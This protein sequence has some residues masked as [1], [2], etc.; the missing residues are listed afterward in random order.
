MGQRSRRRSEPEPGGLPAGYERSRAR[1][2]EIRAGLEPLEEGE[3]PL[4]V[5]IA[6]IVA[7]V[8]ALANIGLAIGGHTIAGGDDA[9]AL[10]STILSTVILLVA[11][12]GMW[13][14]RYWAVL[15]FECILGLQVTVLSLALL[16]VEKWWVAV[17]VVVMIVALSYLFWKLIRAMARLQMPERTPR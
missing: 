11:A 12:G 16:K 9:K 17:G 14:A 5:A 15:G 3:R 4:V 1:A 2:D 7:T 10:Q 6:A 13:A 8:F